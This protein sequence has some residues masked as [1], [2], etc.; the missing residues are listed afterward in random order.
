MLIRYML[1]SF[2]S[3]LVGYGLGIFVGHIGKR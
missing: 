3:M 2:I 1:V